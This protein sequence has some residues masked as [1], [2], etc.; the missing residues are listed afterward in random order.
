MKVQW[1]ADLW[2]QQYNF[3]SH[4]IAMFIYQN[5][6]NFFLYDNL[7]PMCLQVLVNFHN[8][9]CEPYVMVWTLNP[10]LKK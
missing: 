5:N 4:F 7:W 10:I 9:K 6:S 8:A 3:R 2:V 1:Y